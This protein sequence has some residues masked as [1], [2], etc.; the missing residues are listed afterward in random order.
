MEGP[1][2]D[3]GAG[4]ARL[5]GV[6]GL[7]RGPSHINSVEDAFLE[8]LRNSHEAGA[9]NIYVA[10]SLRGRRYRTLTVLDDG[11]G[12]PDS[13]KDLIFEP[14]VTNRHLRPASSSPKSGAGDGSGLSLYHI[15]NIAVKAEVLST[16]QPT[17]VQITLDTHKVPER[18]LQA[19]TRPSPSNLRGTARNFLSKTPHTP[20]LT[21]YYG[22][23]A[24]VMATLI[25]N[26]IIHSASSSTVSESSTE[27]V[28]KGWH[29][30]LE[31]SLRT[32]QRIG[33]GKTKA[34]DAV[35]VEEIGKNSSSERD[36]VISAV[37]TGDAR[38]ELNQEE[39]SRIAAILGEAARTSYLEVGDIRIEY[40]PGEIVV[41]SLVYEPEE[42]YE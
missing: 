42:E 23:P 1:Y 11:H 8:L 12:I 30:G 22:S 27:L 2:R 35:G 28:E 9:K 33:K 4:F 15:R 34:A 7:R 20:N 17:S 29:L 6:E 41:R 31:V 36:E 14:G 25:Q 24:N 16:I 5:T 40:R 10:S 18:A 19:E 32:M 13:Y 39:I 26:R 38:L 3:L 21:I 37:S